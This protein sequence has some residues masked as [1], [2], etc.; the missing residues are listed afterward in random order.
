MVKDATL[1]K[2]IEIM[3]PLFIKEGE[4]ILVDTRSSEYLSRV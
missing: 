2:N 4:A 1:E 3:V